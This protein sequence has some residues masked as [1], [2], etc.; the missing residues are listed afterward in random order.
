MVWRTVL[1]AACACLFLAVP[2]VDLL[3]LS[4]LHHRSI[5]TH[6]VLPA[7]VPFL[8]RRR[9]GLAPTAGALIGLSVHLL[10][11]ALSPAVGFG[12]VWL[13]APVKAPLGALSPLWLAGNAGLC[14]V[15][16]LAICRRL[17]PGLAGPVM[18]MLT[19]GAVGVSYG[20]LNERSVLSAGV[21]L[22]FPALLALTIRRRLLKIPSGA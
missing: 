2:D 13:P 15:L 21:C 18:V 5:L 17:M 7:A 16:A 14:F 9:I 20:L 6:S 4:L 3:L 8:L 11:D 1:L 22:V 10:C 12:Q 19:S